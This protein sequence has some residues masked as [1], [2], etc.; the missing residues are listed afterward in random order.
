MT[1]EYCWLLELP[2]GLYLHTARGPG[3]C[4]FTHDVFE[5]QRF[6]TR[7]AAEA[8]REALGGA[9]GAS[10]HD[11]IFYGD[12]PVAREKLPNQ[13]VIPQP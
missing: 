9:F 5:A 7:E 1:E 13:R 4:G 11:H 12:R 3:V 10:A 8:E 6:P 2:G